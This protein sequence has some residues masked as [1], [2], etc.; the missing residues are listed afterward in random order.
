M[1]VNQ[2]TTDRQTAV[3]QVLATPE[4]LEIILVELSFYDLLVRAQ[5]VNR[6]FH[7]IIRASPQIQKSLFFLPATD[8]SVSGPCPFLRNSRDGGHKM[9]VDRR[10]G[11]YSR[12]LEREKQ[13]PTNRVKNYSCEW[14][15]GTRLKPY[16]CLGPSL[17][18]KNMVLR[19]EA[20]WRNMLIVQPPITEI[21]I[22]GGYE[23]LISDEW[24]RMGALESSIGNKCFSFAINRD[25]TGSILIAPRPVG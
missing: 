15:N 12:S 10:P 1:K 22:N 13:L 16:D 25:G 5:R 6:V 7:S 23:W 19:R 24:L 2:E 18:R 20:S 21:N 9:F 14:T 3:Q 17:G 8:G 4:L 11:Q